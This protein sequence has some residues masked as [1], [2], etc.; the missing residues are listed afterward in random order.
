MV[1][2]SNRVRE[3]DLK[4]RTKVLA[5]TCLGKG[6]YYEE[7]EREEKPLR[8]P[9]RGGGRMSKLQKSCYQE[10]QMLF[11]AEEKRSGVE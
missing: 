7:R 8:G 3:L 6:R 10:K 5:K 11:S 2:A 9:A 1:D 4:N